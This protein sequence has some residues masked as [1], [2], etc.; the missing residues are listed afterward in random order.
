MVADLAAARDIAGGFAFPRFHPL[1]L[2]L[3]HPVALARRTLFQFL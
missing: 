1:R 3:L 2:A